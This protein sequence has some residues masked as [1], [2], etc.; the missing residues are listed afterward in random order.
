MENVD[1]II[2]FPIMNPE[3]NTYAPEDHS[4]KLETIRNIRLTYFSDISEEIVMNA[5]KSI[6]ISFDHIDDN[7]NNAESKDVI[8][9]KEAIISIM[10]RLSGTDHPL[11][12]IIEDELVMFES[13]DEYDDI[14][15][16][17]K[18]KS[19]MKNESTSV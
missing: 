10:C 5:L 17:Y 19:E 16:N 6:S 4:K 2:K 12:D 8:L 11:H 1:N 15:L 9:L 13:Y 18:F 7:L 14:I 3:M